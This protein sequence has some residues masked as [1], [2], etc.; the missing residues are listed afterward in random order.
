MVITNSNT[1]PVNYIHFVLIGPCYCTYPLFQ[2]LFA[3]RHEKEAGV[4]FA[5]VE[6]TETSIHSNALVIFTFANWY[7]CKMCFA[8]MIPSPVVQWQRQWKIHYCHP[9]WT[10]C[11]YELHFLCHMTT[12]IGIT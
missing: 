9:L 11:R 3:V 5:D 2:I 12:C 1:K 8:L 10:I 7:N 4:I 6:A